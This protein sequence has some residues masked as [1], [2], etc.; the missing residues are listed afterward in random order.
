MLQSW[1]GLLGGGCQLD[2][3]RA[4]KPIGLRL[5][6]ATQQSHSELCE[7]ICRASPHDRSHLAIASTRLSA[8]SP[9]CK[10]LRCPVGPG[11]RTLAGRCHLLQGSRH[12]PFLLG[13]VRSKTEA[14]IILACGAQTPL[15]MAAAGPGGAPPAAPRDGQHLTALATL[16]HCSQRPPARIASAHTYGTIWRPR[17]SRRPCWCWTEARATC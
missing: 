4:P 13:S 1:A 15:S 5:R 11:S 14:K 3:P 2:S 8:C 17:R 7:S 12:A 16:H 10:L 6:L 9:F